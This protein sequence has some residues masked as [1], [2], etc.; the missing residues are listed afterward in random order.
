M[1]RFRYRMQG[2]LDIKLKMETQAKQEF[3]ETRMK[4]DQEEER[5]AALRERRENYERRARERLIGALNSR[6]MA[7]NK[8]ALLR[9]DEYIA[10]QLLQ[11]REAE[12]RLEQA[13]EKLA[14]VMKER[15]SHESLKEKAFEQFLLDEKKQ[16][17]KEVDELTSY[18]YGQRQKEKAVAEV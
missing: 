2:I 14:E 11:V 15:K 13:R 9:M 16:E 4:L 10:L 1:A 7:E 3:A 8:E 5:L 17:S 12:K 18:V 6:E